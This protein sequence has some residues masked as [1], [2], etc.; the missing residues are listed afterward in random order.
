MK[1]ILCLYMQFE[2]VQGA[3]RAL[4]ALVLRWGKVGLCMAAL[5]S[6]RC[7]TLVE[8]EIDR[9]LGAVLQNFASQTSGDFAMVESPLK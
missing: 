4:P 7:S 2:E 1:Y 5:P 3:R 8:R 9:Y 6:M